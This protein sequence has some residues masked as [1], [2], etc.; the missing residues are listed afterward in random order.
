MIDLAHQRRACV[1]FDRH[2]VYLGTPARNEACPGLIIGTTEAMLIAP[3]SRG[4]AHISVES[5]VTRRITVVTRRLDV[6][7]TFGGHPAVIDQILAS[8]HLPRPVATAKSAAVHASQ[9]R[10]L[11]PKVTNYHGLGFDTCTA[12]SKAVMRTWWFD[13]PY[14]AVGIYLGGSDAAC[15]QPNLTPSWLRTAAGEGWHFIPMY[16]GPQALFGE[17]TKS[18]G[19]QGTAAAIDAVQHAGQLGFGPG[20]PIYYDMEAYLPAQRTRVLR[21]LSAWTAELHALG[22]ASGVY[23]SSGSGVSDLAHQY[24]LGKYA[25]PDVIFDAL[26]NGRRGTH[27]PVFGPGEWVNHHRVH[28]FSGNIT[29]TY[30]GVAINIDQ[31]FMNV[32]LPG[33]PASPPPSQAAMQASGTSS[34]SQVVTQP[35]GV[36]DVFYRGSDGGLWYLRRAPGEG[37]ARPV[38][39]GGQLASAPS[40]VA[41]SGGHI[42][43]FYRG[44]DGMLW[45]VR[46]GPTGWSRPRALPKLG[47]LGSRPMAVAQPAGVI[48]VFWRDSR[49]DLADGEYSPAGGWAAPRRLGGKLASYPS[50]V[51][52]S[53]GVIQVFWKGRGGSLWH[54]A[55]SRSGRWGSPESLGTGQL[56]SQPQATARRGGGV[57]VFWR[58][59][60][61]SAIVSGFL[62]ANGHWRGPYMLGGGM[63]L[64]LPTPVSAGGLVR[65]F[66]SGHDGRLWQL[67]PP[68]PAGRA[69]RRSSWGNSC[70]RRPSLPLP[71]AGPGSTCSGKGPAAGCGCC[72]YHPGTARPARAS[73]V[74]PGPDAAAKSRGRPARMARDAGRD[75]A[76]RAG[77]RTL[78]TRPCP[79][80]LGRCSPT[81][82]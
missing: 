31:D 44:T 14:G 20:S 51:V 49:G 17:L 42:R 62:T 1:R 63:P 68:G 65:V 34:P 4:V 37:W 55:R 9:V 50:P 57:E 72:G 60:D 75:V 40:A 19:K 41:L 64:S 53:R 5:K 46:S 47:T 16:V 21:F 26:W 48:D 61:K 18:S 24:G 82:R 32:K 33:P 52:S 23:S 36:I 79:C 78:P 80:R 10:P 54:V 13:S 43:V 58:R 22:Y 27:D 45:Q 38:E 69:G 6:T 28:Q 59:Q 56:G 77:S 73:W 12:P 30:G 81:G 35:S 29:Q 25:M 76:A 67:T 39:L 74:V 8:A 2:A 66:F 70:S 71:S 15:A 11:P 3:A 7:A